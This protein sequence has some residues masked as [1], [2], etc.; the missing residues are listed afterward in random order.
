MA[1]VRLYALL[2]PAV[3]GER[4]PEL[5]QAVVEG[6]ATLIQLRDKMRETRDMLAEARVLK[7]VLALHSVPLIINDRVD[8]ALAAGADG[9]HVGQDDMPV[10]DAR[11]LMGADAILG[12]SIKSAEE[13]RAAPFDLV[14]YVGVGGVYATT[15]KNNPQPP[16]GASGLRDLVEVIRARAPAIPI[17]AI[18]GITETNA[19]EAIAAGADGIA[20]IAALARAQNPR[21]AAKR[22]RAIVDRGLRARAGLA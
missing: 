19:A 2:D 22:L 5:A 12:I 8:V 20:V 9:V 13:A 3:S 16:I 18:A 4:L 6:G 14:N 7:R 15:S 21:A 11:R 17:A 1:D 10:E